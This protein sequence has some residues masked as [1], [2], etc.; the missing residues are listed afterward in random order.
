MSLVP[1][2]I[3][4]W[5]LMGKFALNFGS[6]RPRNRV[7]M[8]PSLLISGLGSLRCYS[9]LMGDGGGSQGGGE[10]SKPVAIV[11]GGLA[12]L[13]AGSQL[14]RLGIPCTI[15]DSGYLQVGGRASS[16][17]IDEGNQQ[18]FFDHGAQF[19]TS[20]SQEFAAELERLVE[21]G[22]AAPWKGYFIVID[23]DTEGFTKRED[24][25]AEDSGRG[26]GFCGTLARSQDSMYV[27]TPSMGSITKY[28]AEE[29][30]SSRVKSE[31]KIR[32]TVTDF[33]LIYNDDKNISP[34]WK[35]YGRTPDSSQIASDS[36][37]DTFLGDFSALIIT[38][39]QATMMCRKLQRYKHTRDFNSMLDALEH[40]PCDSF[41]AVKC[42]E[43]VF[44]LMVA[45]EDSWEDTPSFDAAFI[46]PSK[47]GNHISD[48]KIGLKGSDWSRSFQWV[49]RNSSKTG[50]Q[51]KDGPEC[52]VAI[53]ST[54]RTL[55][56]LKKFPL[57]D[58]RTKKINPQTKE[59]RAAVT[60]DLME[61][62]L[63]M[64]SAITAGTKGSPREPRPK[65][66]ISSSQ[67]W[68]R[69]FIS[70]YSHLP[71]DNN[72][73]I[74]SKDAMWASCGDFCADK[75]AIVE[76]GMGPAEFAWLSGKEAAEAIASWLT[77]YQPTKSKI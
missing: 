1:V 15:F 63:K 73:F 11:G 18:V 35:L 66:L 65:I 16:R 2:Q 75:D 36:K 3:C 30:L 48:S 58:T 61:D 46:L 17:Q 60:E 24:F 27:G 4:R 43:P 23:P 53:T 40:V 64:L 69:G 77:S 31:V 38:D 28:L 62:F 59:F 21:K 34:L 50:R 56:L 68:G 10:L 45:F 26:T 33:E 44:S 54:E 70:L 74:G 20:R 47:K 19:L 76:T 14:T 42:G 39:A 37:R 13:S 51:C 7:W 9:S 5:S 8:S 72:R 22:V 12:G 41:G 57:R 29:I 25:R 67:R 6:I 32:H 52:W 55:D 49:S 71:L